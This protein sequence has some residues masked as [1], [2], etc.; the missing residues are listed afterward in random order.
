M[1]G[2]RVKCREDGRYGKQEVDESA[3]KPWMLILFMYRQESKSI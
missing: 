1:G 3:R 2:S